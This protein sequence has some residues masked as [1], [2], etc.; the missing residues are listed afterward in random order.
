MHV[1]IHNCCALVGSELEVEKWMKTERRRNNNNWIL[2]FEGCWLDGHNL[3]L[4]SHFSIARALKFIH[5]PPRDQVA[6]IFCA[7][8]IGLLTTFVVILVQYLTHII[9]IQIVLMNKINR[10]YPNGNILIF[11]DA[12]MEFLFLFFSSM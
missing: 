10:D 6:T 3:L 5:S 9:I 11:G 7:K 2:T 4:I 12:C 1:R 8:F